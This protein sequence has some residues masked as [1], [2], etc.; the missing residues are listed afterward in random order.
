MTPLS[1]PV[2]QDSLSQCFLQVPP[3]SKCDE[4]HHFPVIFPWEPGSEMLLRNWC[5]SLEGA[6]FPLQRASSL[7]GGLRGLFWE[8]LWALLQKSSSQQGYLASYTVYLLPAPH[9]PC[10]LTE[11]YP[12]ALGNTIFSH[13]LR[14]SCQLSEGEGHWQA[15][16]LQ[17]GAPVRTR[18]VC[19]PQA[20][21]L[22][23]PSDM[24]SH[25]CPSFQAKVFRII[26]KS[27]HICL[28]SFS[29]QNIFSYV[30]SLHT[31]RNLLPLLPA[32]TK[33]M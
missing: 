18:L 29:S 15:G 1:V 21:G 23:L 30:G 13:L 12:P 32:Q 2:P 22:C 27:L 33:K 10:L 26:R 16:G 31:G 25:L 11:L 24:A 6:A 3:N 9:F 19:P 28:V 14:G 5:W 20:G 17:L 8:W 4:M 7:K